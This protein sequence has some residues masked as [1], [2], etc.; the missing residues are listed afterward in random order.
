M[1]AYHAEEWVEHCRR[2][3]FMLER[4]APLGHRARQPVDARRLQ[5]AVGDSEGK[6]DAARADGRLAGKLDLD[7][8][9]RGCQ[10]REGPSADQELSVAPKAPSVSPV[11]R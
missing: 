10:R 6:D 3:S 4:E 2:P 8:P 1:T 9:V 7:R 11:E 5:P